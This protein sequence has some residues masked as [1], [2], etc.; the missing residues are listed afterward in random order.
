[1]TI[2]FPE[3]PPR[4]RRTFEEV[5]LQLRSMF[6]DGHLRPGDRLPPER[7]L[8]QHL[9]VSRSALREALRTLEISGVIRLRKGR[10]GGAFI[11]EGNLDAITNNFRDLLTLG[12]LK[13]EE[14]AEARIW[15]A[16]IVIRI[17]CERAGEEDFS[18][19][20]A[21]LREA[22]RMFAAGRHPEKISLNLEFH[23]IHARSTRNPV[24]AMNART[25]QD[26]MREFSNRF[27]EATDFG[28][29][30]RHLIIAAL[31]ARD[32]PRA[33]R[34]LLGVMNHWQRYIFSCLLGAPPRREVLA[35]SSKREETLRVMGSSP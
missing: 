6:V 22:E 26:L 35:A 20:E 2:S 13:F 19:L 15:L 31:R 10:N 33:T 7:E 4:L 25:L 3:S 17:A 32:A 27:D 28:L 8:S 11:T 12:N 5:A 34:V 16:E 1:M 23:N 29:A 24:L 21:N 30:E 9:G 18:A 14:L